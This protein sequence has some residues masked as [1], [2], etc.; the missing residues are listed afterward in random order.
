[1]GWIATLAVLVTTVLSLGFLAVQAKTGWA[2]LQVSREW[3]VEH[4]RPATTKEGLR[5]AA[6]AAAIYAVVGVAFL[7]GWLVD[8]VAG[9]GLAA[10]VVVVIAVLVGTFLGIK[11][12]LVSRNDGRVK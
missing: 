8:G 9:G 6:L 5:G 7:L 3:R 1:M 2:E 10:A 12:S 11:T 4:P